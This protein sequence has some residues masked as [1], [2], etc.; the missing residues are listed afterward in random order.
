MADT[1]SGKRHT[2]I[3]SMVVSNTT[4]V[5]INREVI[6]HRLQICSLDSLA[7]EPTLIDRVREAQSDEE[8]ANATLVQITEG[9]SLRD[10]L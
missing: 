4:P 8:E 3:A 1:W 5:R 10:G 7:G 6:E 9:W 2:V